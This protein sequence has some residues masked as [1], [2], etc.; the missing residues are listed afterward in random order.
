[1]KAL[2]VSLAILTISCIA[3]T[4]AGAGETQAMLADT[5][6]TEILPVVKLTMPLS[7][8]ARDFIT[9]VYGF[10]DPSCSKS[11]CIEAASK[12]AS[13]VPQ[14]DEFGLWLNAGNGY[15]VSY[16]GMRPDVEAMA[17]FDNAKL[18]NYGF[19]F[20]FPY[21]SGNREQANSKQAE[22]CGSLLQ[23]LRDMGL[24]LG[25]PIQT[26]AIFEAVGD[27]AGN[28]VE[29]RLVEEVVSADGSD[30]AQYADAMSAKCEA[31]AAGPDASGRFILIL[32]VE[33]SAFSQADNLAALD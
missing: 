11:Q 17:Q 20:L 9:K 22:F 33:P 14:D 27:Y 8:T 1:M 3:P 13:I 15:A 23:E 29:I 2:L 21:D 24:T 25:R 32:N 19:F 4:D 28:N 30:G 6:R 16:Y 26:D 12:A 5:T 7:L 10:I 31:S 18:S